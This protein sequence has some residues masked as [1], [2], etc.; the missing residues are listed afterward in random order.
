MFRA[1]LKERLTLAALVGL[2]AVAIPIVPTG[3]CR[4]VQFGYRYSLDVLLF[5][6]ILVASGMR[7]RLD[8]LKIAVIILALL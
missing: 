5:M 6:V 1:R 4:L 3:L 8:A 7:Y 2:I